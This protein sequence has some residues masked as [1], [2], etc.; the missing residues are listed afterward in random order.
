M[1]F[2]PLLYNIWGEILRGGDKGDVLL[3]R[4]MKL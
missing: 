2:K 3:W 1:E 4:N